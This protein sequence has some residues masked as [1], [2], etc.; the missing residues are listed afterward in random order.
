MEA[1]VAHFRSHRQDMTLLDVMTAVRGLYWYDL[2]APNRA[3]SAATAAMKRV[4]L[5][6]VKLAAR[7]RGRKVFAHLSRYF[8]DERGHQP[9]YF[10]EEARA[11]GEK[12]EDFHGPR[13]TNIIK[14]HEP[15]REQSHVTG[16]AVRGMYLYA[17]MADLAGLTG[18]AGLKAACERL[19]GS[20]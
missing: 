8:V 16:H 18:D 10:D 7:H 1:A 5:A 3:R 19:S 9:H 2:S 20:I 17:A 14:S 6:L 15:V 12:P 11:R 4:E 13:T